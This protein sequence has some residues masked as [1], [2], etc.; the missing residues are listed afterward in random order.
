MSSNSTVEDSQDSDESSIEGITSFAECYTVNAD[1][2]NA[3]ILDVTCPQES[4]NEDTNEAPEDNLE[5]VEDA[6]KPTLAIQSE[7]EKNIGKFKF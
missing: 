7:E 3:I 2:K 1:V 6:P 4:P 5:P